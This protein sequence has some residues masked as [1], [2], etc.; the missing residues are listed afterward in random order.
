LSED[1]KHTVTL[2]GGQGFESPWVVVGGD[3]V[4]ELKDALEQVDALGLFSDVALAAQAFRTANLL[5]APL[6]ENPPQAP[7][8]PQFKGPRQAP[9]QAVAQERQLPT[10]VCNHGIAMTLKSGTSRKTGKP[11]EGWAP[12]CE[13]TSPGGKCNWVGTDGKEWVR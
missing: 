12:N 9:P 3:T 5:A 4:Q 6:P 1:R 10:Q 11:Y 2:K 8:S 13:D 7:P